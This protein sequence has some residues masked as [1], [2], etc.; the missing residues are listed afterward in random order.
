[1][2][3]TRIKSLVNLFAPPADAGDAWPSALYRC[4]QKSPAVARERESYGRMS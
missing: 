4:L 2:L 1:M 3:Q